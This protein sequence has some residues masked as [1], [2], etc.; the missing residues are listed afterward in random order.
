VGSNGI[1]LTYPLSHRPLININSENNQG[2]LSY[3]N[4]VENVNPQFYYIDYGYFYDTTN[5]SSRKY[6]MILNRYYSG[7]I[8]HEIGLRS[9]IG[10]TNW[11]L[12]NYS[13]SVSIT[14]QATNGESR[15]IDTIH[16]GDAGLYS[17]M[18]VIKYGGAIK[19]NETIFGTITLNAPMN[20]K[21]GITLTVNGTYNIKANINIEQG[22]NLLVSPAGHL[23][24]A[25][26]ISISR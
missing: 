22:G 21:S 8:H 1:N 2:Y 14:L 10:Y 7:I 20:I 26:G 19:Y 15:F 3:I 5:D 18:P 11:N 23:N 6:F 16:V 12:T 9:L 25:P 17:I 24:L 13:D 4:P